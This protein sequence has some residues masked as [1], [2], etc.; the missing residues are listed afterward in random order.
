[1]NYNLTKGV[2]N[3]FPFLVELLVKAV[4]PLHNFGR[5]NMNQNY[6]SSLDLLNL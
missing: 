2:K 4:Q 5:R 1:M 3:G 6:N